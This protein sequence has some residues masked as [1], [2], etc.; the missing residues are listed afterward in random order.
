MESF[1][2]FPAGTA[3]F[4]R[5]LAANNNRQWFT[6]HRH[7]YEVNWLDAA[8]NFVVA[9]GDRLRAIRPQ[10]VADPRVNGSIFRINRDVRFSKDKTPYKDHLDLWFWEGERKTAVSSFFF[11]F[12]PNSILA[13]AGAHGFERDQLTRFRDVVATQSGADALSHAIETVETAGHPVRG[14]EL[15]RV[16][17]GYADLTPEQTRLIKFTTL[18][19]MS[20]HPGGKWA[21][22]PGVLDWTVSR[23][24]Q[25]LPLHV[26]LIEHVAG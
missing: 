3:K 12:T 1:G 2:G 24:Q 16:P 4:L 15:V 23:W 18:W 13:G 9:A 10:V 19:T 11:R 6:E 25:M 8:T 22:Q 5:G 14:P 17:R 20:E 26:W 7:E 21:Q